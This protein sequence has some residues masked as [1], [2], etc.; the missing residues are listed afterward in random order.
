MSDRLESRF[1]RIW[2]KSDSR[3][4]FCGGYLVWAQMSRCHL[5]ATY[6]ADFEYFFEKIQKAV[7]SIRKVRCDLGVSLD[8]PDCHTSVV[9]GMTNFF[10][11]RINHVHP[12]VTLWFGKMW[13]TIKSSRQCADCV[14]RTNR[15]IK[16]ATFIWVLRS[17][18]GK[19]HK[20]PNWHVNVRIAI[21]KKKI[22][23]I[24]HVGP[25]ST[26]RFR[27]MSQNIK[28]PRQRADCDHEKI[29]K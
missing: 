13:E 18:S 7:L 20:T 8:S 4:F 3:I 27:K 15:E 1:A 24:C 26:L 28:S 9:F 2:I 14:H 23:K 10:F 25:D 5:G 16:Y 29:N 12:D 11:K 21:T 6:Y 22:I 19:C 17:D